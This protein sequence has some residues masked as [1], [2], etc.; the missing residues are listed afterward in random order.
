MPVGPKWQRQPQIMNGIF[1]SRNHIDFNSENGNFDCRK[2]DLNENCDEQ[3]YCDVCFLYLTVLPKVYKFW[4]LAFA[5]DVLCLQAL[6]CTWKWS[7]MR[8]HKRKCR[9][10]R[11]HRTHENTGLDDTILK[12]WTSSRISSRVHI[13]FLTK[14]FVHIFNGSRACS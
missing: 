4:Q 10:P 5:R 11:N 9:R 13:H 8:Q 2:I 3:T 7:R 12:L 6:E 1:F 14:Y